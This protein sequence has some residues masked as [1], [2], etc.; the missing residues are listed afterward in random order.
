MRLNLLGVKIDNFSGDEIEEKIKGFLKNER[1]NQIVTVNPEFIIEAQ[2]D[3]DFKN[4][5]NKADLNVVDG[6]GIKFAF[7]RFGKSLK[8]R[9]A[10]VDLM[11]NILRIAEEEGSS[12]FL[13]ANEDGI[14]SWQDTAEAIKKSYPKLKISGINTGRSFCYFDSDIRDNIYKIKNYEIL[15][16][17]F[18]APDQDKFIASLKKR[19]KNIRL[20]MGAG[21]SFDFISGKIIRAPKW[22]RRVGLEWLWR[23]MMQPKRFKRIFKAIIIFPIKIVLNK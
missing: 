6:V 1:L 20:A 18:G 8:K 13:V 3:K 15:F 17:N 21:G 22:I 16:C 2:K 14:S 7:W 11:W 4:A 5:I 9:V 10:G 19:N 12:V 23:L